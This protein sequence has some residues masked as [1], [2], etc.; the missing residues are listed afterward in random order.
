MTEAHSKQN[1]SNQQVYPRCHAF[2][3]N[4]DLTSHNV[5]QETFQY[6][7][8]T[9]GPSEISVQ[10]SLNQVLLIAVQVSKSMVDKDDEKFDF[11]KGV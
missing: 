1:K 5:S 7:D 3:G 2:F 9:I 10:L 6:D 11:N 4:D 8:W